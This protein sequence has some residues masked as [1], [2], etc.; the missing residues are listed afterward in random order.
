MIGA[1]LS[2]SPEFCF[3]I[4]DEEGICGYAVAALSAQDFQKKATEMYLPAMREKY[5]KTEKEEGLTPAE[6]RVIVHQ[7]H[8]V[9]T[10]FRLELRAGSISEFGFRQ[11]YYSVP[12]FFFI[13]FQ[14]H[15]E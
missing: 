12:L 3:V 8:I 1:F 11:Q 2:L 15:E 9:C 14:D 6:V 13:V 10:I 7:K 5:P 4:L